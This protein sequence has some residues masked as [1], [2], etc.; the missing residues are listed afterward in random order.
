VISVVRYQQKL[1]IKI[2]T[3]ALGI[4][5]KRSKGDLI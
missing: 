5:P 2:K 4:V 1:S 3:T